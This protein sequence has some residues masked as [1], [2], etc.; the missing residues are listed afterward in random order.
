MPLLIG[1]AVAVPLSWFAGRRRA[2]PRL[3]AREITN[4]ALQDGSISVMPEYSGNLLQ[5]FDRGFT[6]TRSDAV[7]EALQQELPEGLEVTELN[8]RITEE[9]AV[10][11]DLAKE[12]VAG[13]G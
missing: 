5:S 2:F 9:R 3:G 6:A 4:A 7:Y 1:L 12:F 10:P 13:L 8:R 11:A